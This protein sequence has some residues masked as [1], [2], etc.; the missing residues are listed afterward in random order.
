MI[1]KNIKENKFEYL[2]LIFAILLSVIWGTFNLNKFDK[3]KKN[4]DQRYYNQLLYADLNGVWNTADKFRKNLKEG[5]GYLES[6]PKYDRFLLPSIIVGS[7]Y[8][9]RNEYI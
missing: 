6:I 1:Q 5:N 2:I 9:L 7:Y 4:F 8:F 3:V